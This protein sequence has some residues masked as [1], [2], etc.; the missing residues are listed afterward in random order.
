MQVK[1][2]IVKAIAHHLTTVIKRKVII[3]N[4]DPAND[5]PPYKADVDVQNLIEVDEGN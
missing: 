2:P 4:L 5:R 3:V 1:V